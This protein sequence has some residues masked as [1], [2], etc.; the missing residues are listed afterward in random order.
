MS[1]MENGKNAQK[2][3]PAGPAPTINTSTSEAPG[4]MTEF[5]ATDESSNLSDQKLESQDKLFKKSVLYE[6]FSR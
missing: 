3:Y 4:A 2:R 6:R 1:E 5:L